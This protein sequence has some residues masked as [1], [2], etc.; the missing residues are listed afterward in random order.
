MKKLSGYLI[1]L[2]SI[3]VV[4]HADIKVASIKGHV[5][6]RRNVEENWVRVGVGDIL[7]PN[8]SMKLEK[9]SSTTILIDGKRNLVIPELVILDLSDLRTLTQEELLLKLAMEHVRN[10]RPEQHNGELHI[11]ITTTV[12]GRNNTLAASPSAG[13]SQTATLQL[14]GTRMLFKKGY[15]ATCAL[16]TKE[17]VRQYPDLPNVLDA[18]IMIAAALEKSKLDGEALS[19]YLSIPAA[20]LSPKQRVIVEA[21]IAQLKKKSE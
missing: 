19:E 14:N 11:P 17:I 10:V 5:Y 15:Y 21:K 16:K 2:F 4:A 6:V 18:Q 8:D 3:A 13:P 9:K 1:L 7:K 20:K 12:H